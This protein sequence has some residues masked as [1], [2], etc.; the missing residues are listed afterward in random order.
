MKKKDFSLL[1]LFVEMVL[2]ELR[3]VIVICLVYRALRLT[4]KC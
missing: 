2:S 4:L 3:R 1:S